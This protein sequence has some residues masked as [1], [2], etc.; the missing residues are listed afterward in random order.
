L[1]IR[2]TVDQ[3]PRA[4][5]SRFRDD[6]VVS[7][8]ALTLTL[9]PSYLCDVPGHLDRL[10]AVP[11]RRAGGR[12]LGQPDRRAARP[13]R[14]ETRRQAA[15]EERFR[16][17]LVAG[18]LDLGPAGDPRERPPWFAYAR[19]CGRSGL[20]P[21]VQRSCPRGNG[22]SFAV[23][24]GGLAK[25]P[26]PFSVRARRRLTSPQCP[27]RKPSGW[28]CPSTSAKSRSQGAVAA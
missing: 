13:G 20:Q 4:V 3:Q 22:G 11:C 21:V 14:S 10:P 27:A 6:P 19:S 15:L 12:G 25:R 5:I 7:G 1:E 8:P 17:A 9:D 18:R 26:G 23:A 16:L 24:G 28:P 2:E